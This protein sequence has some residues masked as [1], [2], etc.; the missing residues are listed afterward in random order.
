MVFLEHIWTTM[1]SDKP[2]QG[3]P[4]NVNNL[5]K[6]QTTQNDQTHSNNLLAQTDELLECVQPFCGGGT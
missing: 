1:Y 5:F 3:I 2:N 4:R 6:R